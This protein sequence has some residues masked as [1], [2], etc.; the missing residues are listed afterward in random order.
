MTTFVSSLINDCSNEL[1]SIKAIIDR[2]PPLD[3]EKAYLTKYAL[4][5]SCG[6]VELVYL[7]NCCRL[8]C[9]V[10]IRAKVSLRFFYV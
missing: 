7:F 10:Y 2:L 1:L 6:T 9:K 5:K 4:I 8:F 3:K